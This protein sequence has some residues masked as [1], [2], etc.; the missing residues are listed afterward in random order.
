MRPDNAWLVL[1]E[2][3]HGVTIDDLEYYVYS[4]TPYQRTLVKITFNCVS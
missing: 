4:E 1:S 3:L 2:R